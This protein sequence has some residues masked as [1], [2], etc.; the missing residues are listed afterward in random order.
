MPWCSLASQLCAVKETIIMGPQ[1]SNYMW[2]TG[3]GVTT[4]T[5]AVYVCHKSSVLQDDHGHVHRTTEPPSLSPSHL[6]TSIC[7]HVSLMLFYRISLWW[8][9]SEMAS[10][11][12][13]L[14][15]FRSSPSDSPHWIGLT[16]MYQSARME[17]NGAA[18]CPP[19]GPPSPSPPP[20]SHLGTIWRMLGQL[21]FMT[22]QAWSIQNSKSKFRICREILRHNK[23]LLLF[24]DN[25]FCGDLLHS[26]RW[27][28]IS[29]SF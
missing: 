9:D 18:P 21:N 4:A 6:P 13:C 14:P 24:Y 2:C 25:K 22:P 28:T 29:I 5:T 27:L 19:P 16:Y 17:R 8:S 20:M 23:C 15:E 12:P 11:E 10:N 7:A 3:F 1:L 26:H